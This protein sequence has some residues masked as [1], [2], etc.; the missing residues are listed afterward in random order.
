MNTIQIP[1]QKRRTDTVSF[2]IDTNTRTALEEDARRLGL[3]LNT[4]VSQ[5]FGRY[6]TWERYAGRLRFLPASKDLWREVFQGMTRDTI[7]KIGRR[8]GETSAKEEILFL[9]QRINP[10]TV[11]RYIQLWSSHF[12]AFDHTYDGKKHF[13]TIHHDVN[14]NFSVF[15]KEY[16]SSM[17]QSTLARPAQFETV[18]PSSVTFNFEA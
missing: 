12:D 4:L 2:R 10:G 14:L 6:I 17:I 13:F 8:L 5:I 7:E 3:N 11:F 16:V 9:F 18:S 15:A 1:N